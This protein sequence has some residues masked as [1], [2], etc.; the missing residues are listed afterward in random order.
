MT[1]EGTS[2]TLGFRRR[3]RQPPETVWEA[4]TDPEQLRIWFLARA[5]IDP[6]LGGMMELV[7][8]P[9]NL[10]IRGTILVWDPPRVFEHE[11]NVDPGKYVPQGERS[12][13]RWELAR[14]GEGTLLTMTHRNLSER[15]ASFFV[16]GLHGFLDRLAAHLAHDPLPNWEERIQE[17]R[18]EYRTQSQETG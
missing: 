9:S 17:L 13:V 8:G 3:F 10:H 7:Q 11:W 4:I 15:T 2:V 18:P 6:R 14:D 1:A 16:S 5:K 12:V